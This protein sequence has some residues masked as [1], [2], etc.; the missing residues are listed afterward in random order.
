MRSL[1]LVLLLSLPLWA[2]GE[3]ITPNIRLNK[4]TGQVVVADQQV[5]ILEYDVRPVGGSG[6]YLFCWGQR[7]LQP[8]RTWRF[9]K[10]ADALPLNIQDLPLSVYRF[11]AVAIDAAGKAVAL[12]SPFMAM[13]YGGWKARVDTQPNVA[14]EPP[15]FSDAGRALPENMRDR[16]EITI[17]PPAN[18]CGYGKSIV[19][20]AAIKN[21]PK[22]E[23]VTW[24]LE[25]EGTLKP[26]NAGQAV[27]TAPLEAHQALCLVRLRSHR[28]PDVQAT[29]T[30]LITEVKEGATPEDP[31]SR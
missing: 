3:P 21:L 1:C 15:A 10:P 11:R 9:D 13:E 4:S 26:V 29:A 16:P 24:E 12:P 28:Y 7:D 6:I 19:L 25:G 8:V 20:T 23:Q 27:Y 17:L 14:S 30:V 5:V 2:V 31:Y 18:M 22:D